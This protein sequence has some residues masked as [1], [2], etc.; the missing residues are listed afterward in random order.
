MM[1][2]YRLGA[3]LALAISPTLAWAASGPRDQAAGATK[4]SRLDLPDHPAFHQT[5][6]L[7]WDGKPLED[8]LQELHG[9]YGLALTLA[10]GLG[11]ERT[12]MSARLRRASVKAVLNAVTVALGGAYRWERKGES[13]ELGR[14]QERR[15]DEAA[16]PEAAGDLL[17]ALQ[18]EGLLPKGQPTP[19][20]NLPREVVLPVLR[21]NDEAI[22]FAEEV[23]Q[24]QMGD[25]GTV[26]VAAL[27]P[28]AQQAAFGLLIKG[29]RFGA[30]RSMVGA[31]REA[32]HNP[33][34]S[35]I[36]PGGLT[37]G[38]RDA[39]GWMGWYLSSMVGGKPALGLPL[40]GPRVREYGPGEAPA[41]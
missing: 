2:S 22:R 14:V 36:A 35:G 18:D 25:N 34:V 29:L 40:S 39:G 20:R 26:A 32:A 33:L 21:T 27:S 11:V 1:R 23:Q 31:A 6:D 28:Q 17:R 41:P 12:P 10:D 4:Q 13:L 8:A 3:I 38:K 30:V 24:T 15:W 7:S 16:S 19:S 37:V 5:L 9:R